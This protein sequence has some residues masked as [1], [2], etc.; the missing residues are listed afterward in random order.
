M[1]DIL[2]FFPLEEPRF[3]QITVL[4]E[5]Q[6]AYASESRFVILEAPVGSGKSAI[7]ITLARYFGESHIITPRKTLQN[8]YYGDFDEYVVLMKGRAAYP[9][10][11]E[12]S[13]AKY[14]KIIKLI[15]EGSITAPG[16]LEPN[17]ANAPCIEDKDVLKWCTGLQDCPYHVAIET[18]QV[19]PNII[20]NLHSFIFQ[21]AF[22]GKFDKRNIMIIDEAH[23]I[24]AM[25]R[26]FIS[27]VFTIPKTFKESELPD[28]SDIDQ[29][30]DWFLDDGLVNLFS[31]QIKPGGKETDRE[32]YKDKVAMLRSYA[33]SYGKNFVVVKEIDFIRKF[34]KLKFIPES[35]GKAAQHLL[36]SYGEKVL[37]MSGTIYDKEVFCR[38]LGIDA[39]QAY[40]LRLGSSFP[41]VSRPIYIKP[42]YMVDTS[43][44][45]WDE[46]FS[47]LIEI[48]KTVLSKFPDVR[49]LI[50]TPSYNASAQIINGVKDKRLVSHDRDDF[51]R[52]LEKFFKE[53][54]NKVFVSPVCQQG[55]DFKDDRARFQ[56]I[57]R[58]PY[59]NTNDPFIKKKVETDFP[60][61]NYN[62]LVLFGQQ[63]GRINRSEQDFGAT[64]LIDERFKKFISRNKKA[65]PRW[66]HDAIQV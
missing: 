37:L 20:H 59:M 54:S 27:R 6:K 49:G 32:K 48:I 4:Q 34:T 45:K 42:E 11:I 58:I 17:C 60:W 63:I 1:A 46:N 31:N 25:V 39:D 24:E 64:V 40:F 53:T 12:A 38:N 15:K 5:I 8:Q 21:T 55:V 47:K 9:C 23:E 61:Y 19:S 28:F 18:A 22:T 30:C 36:F 16:R 35:I 57:I 13:P 50:H 43:H 66:I 14:N 65:I 2:S 41:A 3:T 26:E 10:T 56:I 7:A 44:A 62:S 33:E 51:V 29:W 52:Q